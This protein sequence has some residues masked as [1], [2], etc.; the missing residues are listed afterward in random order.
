MLFLLTKAKAQVLML[1]LNNHM[2]LLRALK[3]K[4][5][6]RFTTFTTPPPTRRKFKLESQI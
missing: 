3:S 2:N 5:F 6:H 1:L 4:S